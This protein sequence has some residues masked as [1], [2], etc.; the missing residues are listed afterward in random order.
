MRNLLFKIHQILYGIHVFIFLRITIGGERLLL[1]FLETI[2]LMTW[3]VLIHIAIGTFVGI[4]VITYT[5]FVLHADL[6]FIDTISTI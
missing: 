2:I 4:I 6:K 3:I 1:L 5:F